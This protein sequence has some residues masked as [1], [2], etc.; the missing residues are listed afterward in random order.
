MWVVTDNDGKSVEQ[1]KERFADYVGIDCVS[2]HTGTDPRLK[3][4]EPQ[5]VAANDLATLKEA[6]DVD[7]GSKEQVLEAMLNDKTGSALAIFESQTSI[8]MPEYIQ[9]VF[10]S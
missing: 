4:L 10:S 6:L 7:Y 2:I 9:D 1:V 3:T 5:I 8:V